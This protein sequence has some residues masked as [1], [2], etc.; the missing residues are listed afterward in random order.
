MLS[1]V[2]SIGMEQALETLQASD[3]LHSTFCEKK[4]ETP[5]VLESELEGVAGSYGVIPE[6]ILWLSGQD[7]ES[8][9][10]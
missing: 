9:I 3:D 7:D 8:F 5:K 2:C 1:G 10:Y 6:I 4:P